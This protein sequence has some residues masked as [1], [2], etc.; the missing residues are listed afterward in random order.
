VRGSGPCRKDR[1]SR[2]GPRRF[3][4]SSLL[5]LPCANGPAL[6]HW[7]SPLALAV[8]EDAGKA[9]GLRMGAT[10][11]ADQWGAFGT[12]SFTG[13]RLS[14][15][16]GSEGV[17]FVIPTTSTLFEQVTDTFQFIGSRRQRGRVGN[18]FRRH[19]IQFKMSNTRRPS[20][21][22]GRWSASTTLTGRQAP[23]H[24]PTVDLL[25]GRGGHHAEML[26]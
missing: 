14:L 10:K 20:A 23:Y 25:S 22:A 18:F 2:P 26:S 8:V 13:L 5:W 12:L 6:E 4:R 24:G 3:I 7:R 9:I 17:M 19:G 15:T 21:G 11:R 16:T 1:P